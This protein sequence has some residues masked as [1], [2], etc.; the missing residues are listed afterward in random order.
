MFVG[1]QFQAAMLF[2][3]FQYLAASPM[4]ALSVRCFAF[5]PVCTRMARARTWCGSVASGIC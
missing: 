1:K 5:S 2:D 4:A 3:I